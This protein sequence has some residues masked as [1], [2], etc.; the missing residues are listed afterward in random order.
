MLNI[1]I[2]HVFILK[3]MYIKALHYAMCSWRRVRLC[4]I[5]RLLRTNCATW[6]IARLDYN[7]NCKWSFR[8]LTCQIKKEHR[9]SILTKLRNPVLLC[10]TSDNIYLLKNISCMDISRGWWQGGSL[11][12]QCG[13]SKCSIDDPKIIGPLLL[14]VSSSQPA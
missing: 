14:L 10:G 8:G 11:W 4:L 12:R 5:Y 2:I 3:S 7:D 1:I 6:S 9:N 13:D